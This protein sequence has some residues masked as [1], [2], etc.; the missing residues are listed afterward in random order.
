MVLL[1]DIRSVFVCLFVCGKAEVPRH[2]LD[3]EEDAE[4]CGN[5]EQEENGVQ[6]TSSAHCAEDSQNIFPEGMV[7]MLSG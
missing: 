1:F 6:S 7:R 2:V 4:S 3:D 5:Q